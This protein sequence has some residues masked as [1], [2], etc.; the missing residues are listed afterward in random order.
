MHRHR[1]AQFLTHGTAWFASEPAPC[2]GEAAVLM[3]VTVGGPLD[4]C[5]CTPERLPGRSV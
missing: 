1:I 4:D 5:K 2:D 3:T